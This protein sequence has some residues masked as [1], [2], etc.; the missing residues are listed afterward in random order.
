ML[1]RKLWMSLH[2]YMRFTILKKLTKAFLLVVFGR[3]FPYS[4]IS[5]ISSVIS[6]CQSLLKTKPSFRPSYSF[7]NVVDSKN[8]N[9]F[10]LLWGHCSQRF[11]LLKRKWDIFLKKQVLRC[12]QKAQEVS[13]SSSFS[14]ES[15]WLL[16]FAFYRLL[17]Q[18]REMKKNGEPCFQKE[19]KRFCLCKH[20]SPSVYT[21]EHT[22]VQTN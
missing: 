17:K 13:E 16:A 7:F 6:F 18:K 4:M 12:K 2:I 8:P 3:G 22:L 21:L 10:T 15:F 11:K 1:N 9:I 20:V 19:T 14:K 5:T